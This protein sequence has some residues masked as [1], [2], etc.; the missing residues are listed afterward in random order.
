MGIVCIA[1]QFEGI[2]ILTRHG[3]RLHLLGLQLN[4]LSLLLK[5]KAKIEAKI[6][7]DNSTGA[8]Y[9]PATP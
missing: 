1:F 2:H 7:I 3:D 5:D 9:D 8:N 4:A 6:Q